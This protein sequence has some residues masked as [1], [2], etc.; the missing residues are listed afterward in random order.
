MMSSETVGAGHVPWESCQPAPAVTPE[1]CGLRTSFWSATERSIWMSSPG[2]VVHK[3]AFVTLGH[4]S[5]PSACSG[6]GH[7][8]IVQSAPAAPESPD[9]RAA[10][11]KPNASSCWPPAWR[12]L[13]STR[14]SA[15]PEPPVPTAGGA[16]CTPGWL[17]ATPLLWC[18]STHRPALAGHHGQHPRPA[19]TR[20]EDS[21]LGR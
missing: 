10:T 20:G 15:S 18:P 14:T 13:T 3:R 7:K 5:L 6:V 2:W 19:T 16:G 9:C 21:Q 12:F 4:N 11:R 1:Q 8:G 17:R